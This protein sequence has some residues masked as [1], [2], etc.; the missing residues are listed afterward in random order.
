MAPGDL[1]KVL[2]HLKRAPHPDLIIGPENLSDAGIFRLDASRALVQTVDFFPPIL[3]DPR[4][5]G[6]VAA[7]NSLGDVYAMGGRPITALNIVG[8]PKELPGELLAEILNGGLEK[9]EEAGA[10]LCGGHT[11]NDTEIK[12]GLAVTGLVDIDRILRNDR[13]EPGD[14]LVLT[15]PL[16]MGATSTAIKLQKVSKEVAQAAAEQMATL[17]RGGSEAALEVGVHASTDITGFGLVGHARNVATASGVTARIEAARVPAFPGALDL[18][19]RGI[20]S[21]GVARARE[22]TGD[23]FRISGSVSRE[24][25]DLCLDAE[26]SGGLLLSVASAKADALLAALRR[27]RTP[28]AEVIGE[29]VARQDVPVEVV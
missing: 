27:N 13:A 18:V 29:M 22:Q 19:R 11:V 16:G 21:G 28:C 5:Y 23:T 12:Y 6:R 3:D 14:L 24:L 4:E 20:V 9:I 2:A 8:W 15:K 26:T 1:V 7:A 17:N 25:A 10:A